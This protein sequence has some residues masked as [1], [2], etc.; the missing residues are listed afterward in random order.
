MNMTTTKRGAKDWH[1]FTNLLDPNVQLEDGEALALCLEHVATVCMKP[2]SDRITGHRK[3]RDC[4]C[5]NSLEGE[6]EMQRAVAKY[7][8]SF[9]AKPRQERHSI[10]MEWLRYTT[11]TT[12][13]ACFFIPFLVDNNEHGEEEVEETHNNGDN[14]VD[15]LKNYMVCQDAISILLDYGR[16][17]WKTCEKAVKHNSLPEHGNT[18]KASNNA[19]KFEREVKDDLHAFFQD[20]NQFATPKATRFVRESTGS[21]LRDGEENVL[22]LPT[23]WS[24]RAVYARFCFERGYAISSTATGLIKKEKRTDEQWNPQDEK[25]ICSWARFWSFWKSH[26][27]LIRIATA[28]HD[29]CTECH[30]FFNRSKYRVSGAED[31]DVEDNA[32]STNNDS[33]NYTDTG[34]STMAGDDPETAGKNL[35]MDDVPQDLQLE[36]QPALTERE[37]ILSKATL[38]VQQ[39]MIQRKLANTMIQKA[40]DTHDLPHSERHYC[41]IADFSQNMELP[42]FGA[43][44][45]GDTYYFSP[46]KI[47]VFGIVD[48]SIFGG[49]LSAH[50]YH[51][52]IGKKG[53][54]NVTSM[55]V[56]EFKRLNIMRENQTGK[57]LT[58]IMDNCAGQNKN[59]MVLRLATYLVEAEYFEK[60][61]FVFYIV[62]HTKNACDRWFNMLKKTYRRSNIYSFEQLTKSMETHN[63]INVTVTKASDFRNWD[64]FWDKFYKRFVSGTV[65]STHI[66]SAS[67][68]NKTTLIFRADDLP[69]TKVSSQNL[70]K[71][72][73][74]NPNRPALLKSSQVDVIEAPGIPPIKQV[75]LFS[76]YRAL[77]PEEFRDITCP[78]PSE[79]I[80][81]K[82]KSERNT[83]QRER[84]KTKRE[85]GQNKKHKSETNQK[86]IDNNGS[87]ATTTR[88]DNNSNNN[89]PPAASGDFDSGVI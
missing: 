73:T 61:S 53:G 71:K 29:I 50:V 63:N 6:A 28:S 7:M 2:C 35:E 27:P 18:G 37:A 66:F 84:A 72:G 31:A 74:D 3:P 41:F 24:K 78:E 47:N 5:L 33:I 69:N 46:L 81:N 34:T 38:H 60:V 9:A 36:T 8:V 89:V 52:G 16:R 65:H 51:E 12:E 49:K 54:N 32:T 44:Q 40:I 26:Y 76:K 1:P 22:E 64:G 83:K 25:T 56:N 23:C 45:P 15:E 88:N 48:C 68:E 67:K 20:M 10:I 4:H 70:M 80:K 86:T 43:S 14:K 87:S 30:T 75:E 55:L 57:E 42:F 11:T 19:K 82:I 58:V 39:A 62:G 13:K 79:D 85:M 59:R 77:I 17:K 21:G